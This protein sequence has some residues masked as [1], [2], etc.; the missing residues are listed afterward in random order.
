[1]DI[2][3]RHANGNLRNLMREVSYNPV[4]GSWLTYMNSESESFSGT[5]RASTALDFHDLCCPPCLPCLAA[6]RPDVCGSKSRSAADENYAREIM[7]LF[8]I[9]LWQLNEDGTRLL[10]ATGEPIATYD[11]Q[12]I[13]SFARAWTG[14]RRS[15]K[16]GNVEQGDNYY[17][18]MYISGIRRD[19]FPSALA[20]GC[21]ALSVFFALPCLLNH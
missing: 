13:V 6:S 10:D 14:F 3:L 12:G 17:D 21:Q 5:K 4:M 2:M 19:V 11:N 9:G 18:P 15:L 8:T 7:Q 16:R 20:L 1:M